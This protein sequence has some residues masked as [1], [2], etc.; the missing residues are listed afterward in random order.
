MRARLFF[1]VFRGPRR[2]TFG[3]LNKVESK[4]RPTGDQANTER[5]TMRTA[6]FTAT[7]DT[8]LAINILADEVVDLVQMGQL[9]QEVR[10][11]RLSTGTTKVVVQ[12]GVFRLMSKQGVRVTFDAADVKVIATPMDKGDWPDLTATATAMG[13]D[14]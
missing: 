10:I 9:G 11:A 5:T 6:I 3:C 4:T 2:Q 14:A 12:A 1:V 8:I 7:N 13:R